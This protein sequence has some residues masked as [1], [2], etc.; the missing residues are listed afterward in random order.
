MHPI[1]F[2]AA[3]LVG[4]FLI[5]AANGL[6]QAEYLRSD[7]MRFQLMNFI[8]ALLIMFSLLHAWNLASFLMELAWGSIS[9][10]GIWK[11][12]RKS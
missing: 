7:Q 6:L 11:I 3:G 10:W 9:A 4:V 8:G 1:I 2:D 5:L 12:M